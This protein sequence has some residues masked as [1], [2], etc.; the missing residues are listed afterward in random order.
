MIRSTRLQ[1]PPKRRIA[2]IQN[3]RPQRTRLGMIRNGEPSMGYQNGGWT[4]LSDGTPDSAD[5]FMASVIAKQSLARETTPG[6]LAF[7]PAMSTPPPFTAPWN[8]WSIINNNCGVPAMSS[9]S[10]GGGSGAGNGAGSSAPPAGTSSPLMFIAGML[11]ASAAAVY[12]VEAAFR[13]GA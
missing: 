11:V 13:K 7:T 9:G 1:A 10:S 4:T 8:S 12:L 5:N 6:S 2:V 3:A